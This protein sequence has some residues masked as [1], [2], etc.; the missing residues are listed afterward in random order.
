MEAV[1]EQRDQVA[2][3]MAGGGK[4]VQQKQFRGPR[5]ARLAVEDVSVVDLGGPIM[6]SSHDACS[7]V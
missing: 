3:H 4:S 6:D 5:R 7:F 2:E 1:G